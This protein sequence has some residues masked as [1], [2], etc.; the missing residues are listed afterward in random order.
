MPS[1]F[2]YTVLDIETDEIP[3]TKIHCI[4]CMDFETGETKEFIDNLDEF[5]EFH[6]HQVIIIVVILHLKHITILLNMAHI[7]IYLR[8]R[9]LK[10]IIV[11]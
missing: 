9:K 3:V 6:K 7:N 1:S 11:I 5:V 2:K 10:Y 8:R 4:C